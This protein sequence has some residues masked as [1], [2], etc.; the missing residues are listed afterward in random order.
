M[1]MSSTALFSQEGSLPVPPRLQMRTITTSPYLA[2]SC[3]T[4]SAQ[5]TAAEAWEA[6][7]EHGCAGHTTREQVQ[8][9][10]EGQRRLLAWGTIGSGPGTNG[11]QV[12]AYSPGLS[13]LTDGWL[14]RQVLGHHRAPADVCGVICR[15]GGGAA[16][17]AAFLVDGQHAAALQGLCHN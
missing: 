11:M 8:N 17:P 6:A 13:C 4:D 10:G 2:N 15:Q 12:K 7:G 5:H 3:V 16:H 9:A 14:V 1:L